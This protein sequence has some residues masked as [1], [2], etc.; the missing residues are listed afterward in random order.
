MDQPC[1]RNASNAHVELILGQDPF[2]TNNHAEG[3]LPHDE[4]SPNLR[5]RELL[6][7]LQEVMLNLHSVRFS[8][9]LKYKHIVILL[10]TQQRCQGCFS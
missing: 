9:S 2:G 4:T 6:P 1:T 8:Q 5:Q 3:L 10:K 7:I